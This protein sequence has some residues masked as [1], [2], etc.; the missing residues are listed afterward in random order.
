[1]RIGEES[2]EDPF[3]TK[4]LTLQQDGIDFI[5]VIANRALLQT[6][7]PGEVNSSFLHFIYSKLN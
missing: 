6:L 1:M 5:P 4:L 3:T 7:G 2:T